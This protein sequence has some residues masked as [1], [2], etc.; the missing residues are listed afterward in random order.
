MKKGLN[1]ANVQSN[2]ISNFCLQLIRGNFSPTPRRGNELM[3]KNELFV[4]NTAFDLLQKEVSKSHF[5]RSSN[6]ENSSEGNLSIKRN[7]SKLLTPLKVI[8]IDRMFQKW[9]AVQLNINFYNILFRIQDEYHTFS[10]NNFQNWSQICVWEQIY[11][12]EYMRQ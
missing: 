11:L 7:R 5:S 9:L 1:W 12:S 6:F 4:R 8:Q 2:V 10:D 3:E